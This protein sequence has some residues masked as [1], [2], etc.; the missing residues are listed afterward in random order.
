MFA[1]YTADTAAALTAAALG[2]SC[3]EETCSLFG[4]LF[5]KLEV[6]A[7]PEILVEDQPGIR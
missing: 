3:S 2:S 5:K 7:V 6:R 4:E 1:E